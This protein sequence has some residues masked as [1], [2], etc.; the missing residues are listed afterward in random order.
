MVTPDTKECRSKNLN[1]DLVEIV[2]MEQCKA[3][4]CSG[5]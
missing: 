1:E 2:E 5:L 3:P 4:E